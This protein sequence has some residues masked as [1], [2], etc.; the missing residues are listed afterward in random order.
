MSRYVASGNQNLT[1]T[2][3]T[4]LHI[5][6]LAT[7][8]ICRSRTY[9]ILIADE[10]TPADNVALHTIQRITAIGTNT[11]VVPTKLDIADRVA[12]MLAGENHT[13][14]PT[15]TAAEE[16]LEVAL[17]TRATFRWVAAPGGEI[18]TPAVSASGWGA[19][20]LH[21]SAT[22]AWRVTAYFEE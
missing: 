16:L 2:A 1:T 4:A 12:L 10:G 7:T 11:A 5:S 8:E 15:Y 20:S 6:S 13:V 17:N 18:V 9:D 22:T 3:I 14:E 21:A 19:K